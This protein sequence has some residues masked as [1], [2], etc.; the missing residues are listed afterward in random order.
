MAMDIQEVRDKTRQFLIEKFDID[1]AV[2]TDD[3]CLKD[4]LGIDSLDFVDIVVVVEDVFGFVLQADDVK[5]VS[6][7]E[8][9]CSLLYSKTKTA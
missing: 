1:S 5:Q 7:F 8:Q 6:T 9:L 3:A 4:D 2:I